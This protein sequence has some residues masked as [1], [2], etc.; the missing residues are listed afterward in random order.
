M[1]LKKFLLGFVVV[2]NLMIIPFLNSQKSTILLNRKIIALNHRN[3]LRYKKLPIKYSNLSN[4]NMRKSSTK[5][6][7]N[8]MY[9]AAVSNLLLGSFVLTTQKYRD[10]EE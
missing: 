1:I 2:I 10:K 5:E 9:V 7:L 3:D 8:W 4:K 6:R